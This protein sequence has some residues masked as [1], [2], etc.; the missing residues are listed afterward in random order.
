MNNTPNQTNPTQNEPIVFEVRALLRPSLWA[1]LAILMGVMT[2]IVPSLITFTVAF[3]S[4]FFALMRVY[5]PTRGL[6][7]KILP[8]LFALV[9]IFVT[10][11]ITVTAILLG[12]FCPGGY[13]LSWAIGSKKN[14]NSAVAAQ[15]LVYLLY[16]V[17]VFVILL[18]EY[19]NFDLDNIIEP[20][21]A[22]LKDTYGQVYDIMAATPYASVISVTKNNFVY[23]MYMSSLEIIPSLVILSLL[24]TSTVSYWTAKSILR[25]QKSIDRKDIEFFGSFDTFHVSKVGGIMY[26]LLSLIALFVSTHEGIIIVSTL[27]TALTMIFCYEGL[28]FIAYVMKLHGASKL[29]RVIAYA[30]VFILC[31]LPFGLSS[32]LSILGLMDCLWHLRRFIRPSARFM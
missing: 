29:V 8:V 16:T 2:A 17:V 19:G 24:L 31:I 26:V 7:E 9:A 15:V 10:D 28:S 23:D 27:N 20:F 21:A 6:Y 1:I 25:K 18:G 30:V 13:I 4:L 3:G 12:V 32:I 5:D 14:L 22:T 11:S